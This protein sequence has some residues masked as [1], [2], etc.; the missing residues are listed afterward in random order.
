MTHSFGMLYGTNLDTSTFDYCQVIS[1]VAGVCLQFY[2]MNNALYCIIIIN[3][4]AADL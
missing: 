4:A 1:Q 2:T 3:I